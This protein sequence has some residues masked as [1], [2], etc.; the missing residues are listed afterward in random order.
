MHGKT[1]IK[2]I[3]AFNP[4]SRCAFRSFYLSFRLTILTQMTDTV[5]SCQFI[6]NTDQMIG[7]TTEEQGFDSWQNKKIFSS[8]KGPD[9]LYGP[10]CLLSRGHRWFIPWNKGAA[11]WTCPLISVK[12]EV[13]NAWSC[14]FIPR[15]LCTHACMHA[16]RVGQ[17]PFFFNFTF[18]LYHH[19]ANGSHSCPFKLPTTVNPS[20]ISVMKLRE[21]CGTEVKHRNLKKKAEKS[22]WLIFRNI[23]EWGWYDSCLRENNNMAVKIIAIFI[24]QFIADFR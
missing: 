18:T 13:K 7:G 14:T 2:A 24:L 23:D 21:F 10:S 1:T 3:T 19:D 16:W 4:V 6:G 9:R 22:A 5:D 12:S 8:P 20:V 11:A 15:Q 17:L